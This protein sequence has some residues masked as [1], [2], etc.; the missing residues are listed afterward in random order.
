L[1][2][3][4]RTNLAYPLTPELLQRL[5]RST[6]QVVVSVDGDKT[7]HD[8]RRGNGTYTCTVEN[9]KQLLVAVSQTAEVSSD[10][11]STTSVVL[12]TE[13]GI[14]AVLPA[15]QIGGPDGD[16]VRA[17]GEEL[18]VRVRFKS[19][20]PL[21]RGDD[22]DLKPDFYSSLDDGAEAIAYG[23]RTAAT[24]GLGMNLYIGPW[25]ECYPCYALIGT[26]HHLGNALDDGLTTILAQNDAYRQ[27][28]V[29]SNRQCCHCALRY[30]CGGFCRAWRSSDDSDAPPIDCAAL[31]ERAR[32]LLLSALESL[33]VSVERWLAAGLPVP[34]AP[35]KTK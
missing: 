14:T 9:L 12:S 2:T 20:L 10:G 22:L 29:D 34:V 3:V 24:C 23:A 6:D 28:T 15:E 32:S 35:P 16:A 13:V 11:T 19:V 7:S 27:V 1:Q 21:G 18:D 26:R 33:E 25:G 30:V 4:L 17:L 31:H 8:S 5:I